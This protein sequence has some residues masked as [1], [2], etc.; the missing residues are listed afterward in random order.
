MAVVVNRARSGAGLSAAVVANDGYCVAEWLNFYAPAGRDGAR[1]QRTLPGRQPRPDERVT[2]YQR[3]GNWRRQCESAPS[4]FEWSGSCVNT[5]IRRTGFAI[6]SNFNETMRYCTCCKFIVSCC[7]YISRMID[8]L[9]T[10][11]ICKAIALT[12]CT[13]II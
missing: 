12:K 11:I 1:L 7:F 4:C 10:K 13:G 6:V 5:W 9:A 2:R 3:V 8:G